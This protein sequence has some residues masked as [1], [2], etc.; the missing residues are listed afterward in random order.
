MYM[1]KNQLKYN[2][3]SILSLLTTITFFPFISKAQLYVNTTGAVSLGSTTTV[4]SGLQVNTG[5]INLNSANAYQIGGN[6][7]LWYNNTTNIFVGVGAGNSGITTSYNSAFGN[8][9]LNSANTTAGYC[10]AFGANAL[11]L[12]TSGG[13]NSAFGYNALT[14]NTSG[15]NNVAHGWWAGNTNTTGS[16]NTFIGI[17]AGTSNTTGSNN[18]CVGTLATL[19]AATLTNATAIG[20][21]AVVNASNKMRLGNASVTIIEGA[22]V[23]TTSD[24]RFKNNI[25]E[26]VKGLE[27]IKKLRPV[28]YNFDTKKFDD[29]LIKNMPDSIKVKHNKDMDFTPST[30]IIRTGFVAQE[31]EQAARDCG[32][33][34]DGVSAPVDENDNYSLAYS[35]FVV[36]LIKSIQE[37]SQITDSLISNKSKLELKI[38]DLQNQISNCCKKTSSEK[39]LQSN[40]TTI[41][42][43]TAILFQNAPNPFNQQTSIQYFIPFNASNASIMIFDLTGKPV[44]TIA[45]KNFGNGAIIINGNELSP[46]MFVYSLLVDGKI[47]DTKSMILT[48]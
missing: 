4:T 22:V 16:N 45:V 36:P 26:D 47:I 44:N 1:K 19:S 42:N 12:N 18:T 8:L 24:G 35:Q 20:N 28:T 33:N 3:I 31:V 46:G 40:D 6:K 11:K 14:A 2:R 39:S 7:A 38:T 34:F 17:L 5:N 30:N 23:Y 15:S 13:S 48:Q 27:F 41:S 21:G 32:Y 29:F 9:A 25:K 37:L 43:T 10:S